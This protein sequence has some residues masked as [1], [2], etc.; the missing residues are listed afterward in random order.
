MDEQKICCQ[1]L[2]LFNLVNFSEFFPCLFQEWSSVSYKGDCLGVHLSYKISAVELGFEKFF[3]FF[4]GNLLVFFFHFHCLLPAFSRT[5]IIII[6][7]YS[8]R[9]LHI[10]V[11]GSLRDSKSPWVS[12][13]L[14]SIQAVL[15]NVIVWMVSILPLISKSSSP[16]NNPLVTVPIM[17]GIIV[18]CIFHSFFNFRARSRYLSYFSLS[19]NFILWSAGTANNFASSLFF[20]DFHKVWSSGRD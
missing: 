9:V 8:F 7:I 11:S 13:T 6:I 18:T 10:S 4:S 16:F 5:F 2:C 20:V 19:F 3:S 14:L 15:N 12:R 17:I 1:L